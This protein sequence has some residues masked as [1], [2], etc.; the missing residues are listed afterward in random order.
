MV[1]RSSSTAGEAGDAPAPVYWET[2]VSRKQDPKA[3]G[4]PDTVRLR[5]FIRPPT[6]PEAPSRRRAC[7]MMMSGG[8]ASMLH[9]DPERRY[10][11]GRGTGIDI[12]LEDASVSRK[13]LAI[14]LRGEQML[15][16]DLDSANGTYLNGERLDPGRPAAIDFGDFVHAGA[17]QMMIEQLSSRPVHEVLPPH[18]FEQ[19]L[20]AEA[21]RSLRFDRPLSVLALGF[22]Q[23]ASE[24]LVR[25]VITCVRGMDTVGRLADGGLVVLLPEAEADDSAD[26][27]ARIV[28][29]VGPLDPAVRAGLASWP[30]DGHD[31][32]ALIEAACAAR[33]LAADEEADAPAAAT[34]VVQLGDR[35]AVFADKS[36]LRLLAMVERLARAD[37]P[38]LILGETGAGKEI[39]A[40][41]LHL[42]SGRATGPFVALNCAAL[43]EALAEDELFG[44]V[45][46]AF[47]SAD[48]IRA[49][50]LETASGGTLFLDEIGELAPATQAK[51]LRVLEER[52]FTRLGSDQSVPID[53]RI[54][55][56]TNRDLKAEIEAGRFRADLYYRLTVSTIVVP[57]LRERPREVVHLAHL[58]AR[59]TTARLGWPEVRF[60]QS[61]LRALRDH[62]WPGNV[63]ELRNVVE[64]AV[65]ISMDGVIKVSDLP[66]EL[67]GGFEF[68][69]ET[70]TV[71]G[72]RPLALQ[73]K[74]LE[75]QQLRKALQVAGGVKKRAAEILDMPLRTFHLKLKRYGLD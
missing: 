68:D 54:I 70:S 72:I 63:R 17:T 8:K 43:P 24:E 59:E 48:G 57:P 12:T 23:A 52:R 32:L 40:R 28:D 56:A 4:E 3:E 33:D 66:E 47:T 75:V 20:D 9:L 2:S 5:H 29:A 62:D 21:E 37:L 38:V 53:V 16:T 19:L 50:K 35:Q 51:L 71:G 26:I 49:G 18:L 6:N 58:L 39:F 44:H 31:A 64:R 42:H 30:A 69:D 15:V 11:L 10:L 74:E 41:A 46:G 61:A 22:D 34:R 65:A 36:M 14:E 27:A 25:R 13:H 7:L 60:E 1:K 55:A 45:R 73:V 67:T